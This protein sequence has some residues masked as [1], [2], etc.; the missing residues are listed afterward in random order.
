MAYICMLIRDHL[1]D[2]KSKVDLIYLIK[3]LFIYLRGIDSLPIESKVRSQELHQDAS[4]WQQEPKYL[5]HSWLSSQA[6]E[7]GR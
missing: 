7:Q 4:H 3:Y 1:N 6:Q 5:G 2:S